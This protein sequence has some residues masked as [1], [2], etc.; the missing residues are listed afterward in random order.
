MILFKKKSVL[1]EARVLSV[2]NL[3]LT[4]GDVCSADVLQGARKPVVVG[5][6]AV[7]QQPVC[8]GRPALSF[9]I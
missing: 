8:Q 6:L 1:Q 3:F 4:N 2:S 7:P 5:L 9:T